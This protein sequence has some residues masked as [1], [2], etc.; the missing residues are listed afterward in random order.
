MVMVNKNIAQLMAKSMMRGSFKE[1]EAKRNFL[2]RTFDL[3]NVG[4]YVTAGIAK[5]M[6]SGSD[7]SIAEGISGGLKAGNPFGKGYAKGRHIYS[8]VLDV[9]GWKPTTL[10]GKI[11][12][13]VVGFAGDVLLDPTT[14]LTGGFSALVKGTG[15]KAAAKVGGT[16]SYKAAKDI[17]E[18]SSK[19]SGIFLTN[20][21]LLSEIMKLRREFN[22]LAGINTTAKEQRKNLPQI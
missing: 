11:A 7:V 1:E 17:V 16:L 22:K 6:L 14:Y 8:E 18:A 20:K 19:A 4:G 2:T 10:S 13:G 5:G 15:K 9:A 3:L 21:D 12:R